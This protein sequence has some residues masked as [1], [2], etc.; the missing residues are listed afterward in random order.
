MGLGGSCASGGPYEI[1]V[2]CPDNVAAFAPLSIY[3]GLLAV[4]ISLFLARGFGTPLT[5]WGWPVLFIGLGLAF[6]LANELTGYI[7]G[8][9]F[10]VMGAAPLLLELRGSPQRV[11]LGQRAANG[12]QFYEGERARRSLLSPTAPNPENAIQPTT[13]HWLVALA[14]PVLFGGLGIYVARLWFG[15]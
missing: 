3:G 2:E 10:V 9:L 11:F 1:A 4:G 8:G 14:M 12:V 5:T 6:L 7:I 15:V 13:A